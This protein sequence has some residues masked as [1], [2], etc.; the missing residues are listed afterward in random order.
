MNF[1]CVSSALPILVSC[2]SRAIPISLALFVQVSYRKYSLKVHFETGC[3]WFLRSTY[4]IP[5]DYDAHPSVCSFPWIQRRA[6]LR[7]KLLLYRDHR[8]S[9]RKSWVFYRNLDAADISLRSISGFPNDQPCTVRPH[10]ISFL[11]RFRAW[12]CW[13]IDQCSLWLFGKLHPL[14]LIIK[15]VMGNLYYSL[16]V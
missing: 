6:L 15:S 14:A 16:R 3:W 5:K 8:T 10:K 11:K 9:K 4:R 1:P 12:F 7:A 13:S 2:L